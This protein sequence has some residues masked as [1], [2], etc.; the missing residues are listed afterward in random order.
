EN[1]DRDSETVAE[2]AQEHRSIDVQDSHVL[3]EEHVK[4][5]EQLMNDVLDLSIP[6]D[7]IAE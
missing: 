1:V 2:V 6:P 4:E 5:L 3:D 7:A